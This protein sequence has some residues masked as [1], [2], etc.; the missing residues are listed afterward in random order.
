MKP[1][2][3]PTPFI[4]TANHFS[5]LATNDITYKS[6]AEPHTNNTVNYVVDQPAIIKLPPPTIFVRGILD[7]V[8]LS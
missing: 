3:P 4:T 2:N 8:G 6:P 7:F 5:S 1:S